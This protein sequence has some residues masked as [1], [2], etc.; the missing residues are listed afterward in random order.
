MSDVSNKKCDLIYDFLLHQTL[1]TQAYILYVSPWVSPVKQILDDCGLS[2]ILLA[3]KF[4]NRLAETDCRARV[5]GSV[6]A[7]VAKRT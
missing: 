4:S 1:L 5:E 7:K 6:L 3:L 2:N